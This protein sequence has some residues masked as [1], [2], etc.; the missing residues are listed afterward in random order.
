[1]SKIA[2]NAIYIALTSRNPTKEDPEEYHWMLWLVDKDISN[3]MCVHATNP[4]KS[5]SIPKL[6]GFNVLVAGAFEFQ[7][8]PWKAAASMNL[9][10]LLQIGQLGSHPIEQLIKELSEVPLHNTKVDMGFFNCRVWLGQALADF[11]KHGVI[12]CD[13]IPTL[14]EEAID[15]A[16]KVREAVEQGSSKAVVNISKLSK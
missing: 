12:H 7:T 4:S 5:S 16:D 9:I 11:A 10:A 15:E 2:T 8:K 14:E 3:G 6:I 1:M 13:N